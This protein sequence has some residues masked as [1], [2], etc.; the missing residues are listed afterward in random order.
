MLALLDLSVM[1]RLARREAECSVK[2]LY[3]DVLFIPD[4]LRPAMVLE[5]TMFRYPMCKMPLAP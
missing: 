4:R 3:L 1:L 5:V 2:K